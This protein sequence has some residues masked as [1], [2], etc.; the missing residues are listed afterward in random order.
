ME[1]SLWHLYDAGGP[2]LNLKV[3][4]RD[5]VEVPDWQCG[6]YFQTALEQAAAEGWDAYDREPGMAP[7]EYAIVHLKRACTARRTT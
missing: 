1:F 4:Y 5:D 2:V 3:R 6:L 7:G